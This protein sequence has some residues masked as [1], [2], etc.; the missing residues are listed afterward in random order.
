[1]SGAVELV[2][3]PAD[4]AQLFAEL[5][6][7]P[8]VAVDT[9]AASFHRYHDRIYLIQVSSR[10]RTA[11]LDPLALKDLSGLAEILADPAIEILFHDA[12]YDLR[13]LDRDY[14]FRT[15]HIF[16]T[17]VA[18]EFLNEP[19]IGLAA[20][21]EKY[22][23]VRLD[24]KYQRADWSLRPLSPP[25]LAY[26]AADTMYLAQLRDLLASQLVERGRWSWAEEEFGLLE[27]VGW[28]EAGPR[29]EAFLRLKGARLLKGRA[30][31][32]LRELHG[33]RERVAAQM[34]RATF[35][36]LGNE[37][38]LTLAERQPAN[39]EALRGI[40]GLS[41]D[42]IDRRGA[43]LLAAVERG[44]T[45]P[46][47][48]LPVMERGRRMPRDPEFDAALE[49]LKVARN[50]AAERLG[51]ASGVLC[52]NGILEGAARIR[53]KTSEELATVPG[54][55]RWQV[56]VLGAELLAAIGAAG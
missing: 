23:G 55:R 14:G 9:E 2:T 45:A 4:A 36:V 15:R 13:I 12:D 18:A 11:V 3:D 7:E 21:L 47:D 5:K 35:R 37:V 26:A 17:K 29:E 20:L 46:L 43:E 39:P 27:E 25:M 34:D 41:P 28:T 49:R 44:M 51:L 1:M 50:A 48:S 54:I 30:L 6:R 31:A 42:A 22:L 19:G 10:T 8:L 24:K 52:P 40:P 56:E 33:W 38:L 16:D 32:V 53:A